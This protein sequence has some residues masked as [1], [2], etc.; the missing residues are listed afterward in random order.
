MKS[1]C[2]EVWWEDEVTW[3]EMQANNTNRI[4]SFNSYCEMQIKFAERDGFPD[5]AKRIK[6]A[7]D[8]AQ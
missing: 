7:K 5:L 3:I 8:K 4:K 2:S 1:L 6:E